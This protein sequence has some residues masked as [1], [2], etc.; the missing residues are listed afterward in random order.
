MKSVAKLEALLF[1]YGES[2]SFKKITKILDIELPEI[3]KTAQELKKVLEN[4][5]KGLRLLIDN[6]K[7]QLVS[8]PEFSD[9]LSKVIREE[10]E[11]NL[12]PASL[13][14]LTIVAYRGPI[15]RAQIEYIRGVNSSFILRSLLM[16]GL[17]ER[18][19][20]PKKP[21]SYLYQVTFDF[22]KLLG[23]NKTE[24]LPDFKKYQEIDKINI[25]L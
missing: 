14:T 23:I 6:Q 5:N 15:S 13:E 2:L 12:T 24:E 7:V 21:M 3:E 1:I 11:E 19:T 20:N 22:L 18:F 25:S 16:R 8:A 17:I 9:L 4:E 10:F